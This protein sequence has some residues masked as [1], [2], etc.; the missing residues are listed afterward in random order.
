MS[1]L[2]QFT[3]GSLLQRC[4]EVRQ[5]LY[6]CTSKASNMSALA[7]FT[8]GSLLLRCGEVR[9]YLYFCTSK[10][11]NLS[12]L[13][14]FTLGSQLQPASAVWGGTAVFVLLY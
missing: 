2:A 9:Q 6:F 11:S 5:Y 1:A 10:A 14:Q 3:L 8:L 7:Q 13:A 12:A 4:G